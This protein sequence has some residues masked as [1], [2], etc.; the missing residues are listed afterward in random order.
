MKKLK[1]VALVVAAGIL[2]GC[3]GMQY[4]VNNYTGVKPVGWSHDGLSFLV[5]DKPD[6]D[7]MMITASIGTAAGM[8]LMQGLTLGIVDA[9]FHRDKYRDAAVAWLTKQGRDCEELDTVL[10]IKP[11]W[12]VKYKCE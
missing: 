7:R 4:A 8:G 11:Q 5:Y 12:E 9:D 2:T 3:A 6:E 1:L 10:I